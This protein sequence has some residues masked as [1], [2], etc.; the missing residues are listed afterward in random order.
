M[1]GHEASILVT[2]GKDTKRR[3]VLLN[4]NTLKG[5]ACLRLLLSGKHP[6]GFLDLG[7]VGTSGDQKELGESEVIRDSQ[8]DQG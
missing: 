3:D 2:P 5:P 8:G 7:S 6:C 1:A 4:P